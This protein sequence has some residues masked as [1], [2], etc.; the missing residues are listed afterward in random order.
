MHHIAAEDLPPAFGHADV[1][2]GNH[3]H[4]DVTLGVDETRS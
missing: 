1:T 4:A 3:R 2:L